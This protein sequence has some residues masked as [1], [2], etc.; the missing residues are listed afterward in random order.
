MDDP[1]EKRHQEKMTVLRFI[2][3]QLIFI[4]TLLGGILGVIYA[5][6]QR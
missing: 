6:T 4:T 5:H 1:E 3:I 2:S